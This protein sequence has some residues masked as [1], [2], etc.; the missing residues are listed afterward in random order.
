[1]K[2]KV[3]NGLLIAGVLVIWIFV[4]KK[5]FNTFENKNISIEPSKILKTS[6]NTS[7]LIKDTFNL[8]TSKRDP[9]LD[10]KRHRV[11]VSNKI[12]KS[13]NKVIKKGLNKKKKVDLKLVWPKLK[14]FGFIKSNDNVG[15]LALIKIDNKL[16]RLREKE[17]LDGIYINKI[18]KDS[19]VISMNSQPKTIYK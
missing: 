13:N 3:I 16:K 18:F 15:K 1:M 12:K 4:F 5:S 9:F 10:S 17:S 11:I 6:H 7:E 8:N 2:K 19:I 14:Y